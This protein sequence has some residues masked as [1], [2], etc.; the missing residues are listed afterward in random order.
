MPFKVELARK[1]AAFP[2]T[3][4]SDERIAFVLKVNQVAREP[5]KYSE[6]LRDPRLSPYVLRFFRF[7]RDE[8]WIAAFDLD[9]PQNRLRIVECRLIR[10]KPRSPPGSSEDAAP[11]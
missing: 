6:P 2:R 9:V 11:A 8:R 1:V 7:G 10:G 5:I 4:A 3:L